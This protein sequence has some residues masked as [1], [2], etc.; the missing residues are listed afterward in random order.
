[1]RILGL[2]LL[3]PATEWTHEPYM[4]LNSLES[5]NLALVHLFLGSGEAHRL[6]TEHRTPLR[7][8]RETVINYR[9]SLWRHIRRGTSQT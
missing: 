2:L 1:M 4:I 6:L 9:Q 3:S 7:C 8:S 5:S